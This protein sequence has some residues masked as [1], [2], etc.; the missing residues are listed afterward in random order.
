MKKLIIVFLNFFSKKNS[1]RQLLKILFFVETKEG[2]FYKSRVEII[3]QI[4]RN[5]ISTFFQMRDAKI[6]NYLA[7]RVLDKK[8]SIFCQTK[9]FFADRSSATVKKNCEVWRKMGLFGPDSEPAK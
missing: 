3:F 4:S 9:R 5:E 7:G 8:G 1:K 6:S 2:A